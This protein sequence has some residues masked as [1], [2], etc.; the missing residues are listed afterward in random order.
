[1]LLIIQKRITW[2]VELIKISHVALGGRF[3][4]SSREY[5]SVSWCASRIFSLICRCNDLNRRIPCCASLPPL[6][7]SLLLCGAVKETAHLR[8]MR[9][10]RCVRFAFEAGSTVTLHILHSPSPSLSIPFALPHQPSFSSLTARAPFFIPAF[11][12]G[13]RERKKGWQ[14]T[15]DE[16]WPYRTRFASARE[17]ILIITLA[18][19][20]ICE[21]FFFF[22]S[23]GPTRRFLELDRYY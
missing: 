14:S 16:E 9:G 1:M 2:C 20:R 15:E 7:P 21:L 8:I 22:L 3:Q 23:S 12:T 5:Q 19:A 4:I 17:E 13:R 18:Q 10:E 6:S 11:L